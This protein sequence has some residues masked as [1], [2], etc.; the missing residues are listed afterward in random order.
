MDGM[1]AGKIHVLDYKADVEQLVALDEDGVCV[2]EE[3]PVLELTV[4][5]EDE[6]T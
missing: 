4:M 6:K 2:F 5:E 3:L 1:I